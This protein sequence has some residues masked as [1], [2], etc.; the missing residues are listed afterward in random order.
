MKRI[1]EVRS[2]EGGDDSKI[3]VK[4]L[5]KAYSRLA[6]AMQWKLEYL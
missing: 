5:V 2:A 4:Q 1:I 3:F 6:D